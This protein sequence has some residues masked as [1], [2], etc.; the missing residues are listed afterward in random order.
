VDWTAPL[1]GPE[2]ILLDEIEAGFGKLEMQGAGLSIIDHELE[3][4]EIIA[5]EV[6]DLETLKGSNTTDT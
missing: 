2:Y 3:G 1:E 5:A 6:Y 4:N